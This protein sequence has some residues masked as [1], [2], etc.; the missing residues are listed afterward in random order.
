MK[1]SFPFLLVILALAA[2]A[3][4]AQSGRRVA[5]QPVQPEASAPPPANE[6]APARPPA[7]SAGTKTLPESVLNRELQSLDKGSFRLADFSGKVFVINL[8]A[9]WCGPCRREIPEYEEVRKAYAARGVEFI[10]LT[11]EDPRSD[12]GR[13]KKF[14]R[15]FDFGFRIGWLD[16]ETAITLTNGRRVIPQT[17]V[18]AADGHVVRHFRG[19]SPGRG[20]AL[21][22]ESLDLALQ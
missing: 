1:K 13:V 16:R 8:W 9:T 18:I 20:A 14:V 10:A 2:H 6:T 5:P 7:A 11:T 21:L 3:A 19:Y 4:S 15:E 22:R 17:F 12:E